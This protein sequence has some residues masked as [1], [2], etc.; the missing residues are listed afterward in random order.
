LATLLLLINS[1]DSDYIIWAQQEAVL[2]Q[3]S[4]E[5]I[6]DGTA[7]RLDTI[8]ELLEQGKQGSI[9]Q[10][11]LTII[12]FMMG[13]AFVIFGLTS[14]RSTNFQPLLGDSI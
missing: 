12:V 5:N 7:N 8:I 13:L 4:S 11:Y 14:G 6:T 3:E 1:L 10:L 9:I 2:G